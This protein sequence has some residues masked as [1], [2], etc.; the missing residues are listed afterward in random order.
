MKA[1]TLENGLAYPKSNYRDLA[2]IAAGHPC[3][4]GIVSYCRSSSERIRCFET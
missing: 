3:S 2:C 4:F 1:F